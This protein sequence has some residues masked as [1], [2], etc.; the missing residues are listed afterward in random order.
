VSD[1][2][3][4]AVRA[5]ADRASVLLTNPQ[6][7][8]LRAYYD[9]LSRWART[10]NLT[11]LSLEGHPDQSIDRLLVEPLLAARFFPAGSP[12]WIDFGTGSGSPAV[13]LRIVQPGGSLEMI[14]SRERK[15]AFLREV[16]RVLG[17]AQT[18]VTTSRIEAVSASGEP[19][20]ADVITMRAV[21]PTFPILLAAAHLLKPGGRFL[22]FGS[23]EAASTFGEEA[24]VGEAGFDV[25]E[26]ATLLEPAHG[27]HFLTRR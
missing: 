7:A 20:T 22:V 6:I 2:F 11:S 4:Q 3:D 8:Q 1:T 17:L 18:E 13:P 23:G 12:R 16:L 24:V 25:T 10:I 26:T 15:T 9:L 14:E 5:R 19:A 21:R 27:L